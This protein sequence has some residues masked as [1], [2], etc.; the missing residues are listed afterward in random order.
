M[1]NLENEWFITTSN[2]SRELRLFHKMCPMAGSL[3]HWYWI[4][5]NGNNYCDKCG[6]FPPEDIVTQALLLGMDLGVR[7]R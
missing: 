3:P 4:G 7:T 6:Q 5:R 1:E 2:Y